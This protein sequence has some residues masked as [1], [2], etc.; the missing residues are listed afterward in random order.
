[1]LVLI[2]PV[3]SASTNSTKHIFLFSREFQRFSAK[4]ENNFHT[5][6]VIEIKYNMNNSVSKLRNCKEV[7]RMFLYQYLLL[8][9]IKKLYSSKKRLTK[10]AIVFVELILHTH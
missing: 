1:M 8:V 4:L 10:R 6:N 7:S 9:V 2:M 3:L 5:S